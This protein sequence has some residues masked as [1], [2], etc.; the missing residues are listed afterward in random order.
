MPRH[1]L[2]YDKNLKSTPEWRELYSKWVWL[3]KSGSQLCEEFKQFLEFYNWS[4]ANGY[5]SGDR[6][7]R[8]DENAPYSPE[9]CMWVHPAEECRYYT[10]EQKAWIAKW[11]KTVNRIRRYF[12]IET[13]DYEGDS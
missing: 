9:N 7:K 10:E 3:R 5:V 1:N 2:V 4:M 6:L 13:F 11:N 12:G 8:M